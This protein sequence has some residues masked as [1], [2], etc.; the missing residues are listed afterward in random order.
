[1]SSITHDKFHKQIQFELEVIPSGYEEFT[2]ALTIAKV[3]DNVV[4]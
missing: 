3:L 1:M 2:C 4:T